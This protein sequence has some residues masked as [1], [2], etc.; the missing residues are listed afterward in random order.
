MSMSKS[1]VLDRAVL[2]RV[3]AEPGPADAGRVANA[4]LAQAPA[5]RRRPG[6]VEANPGCLMQAVGLAATVG[7]AVALAVGWRRRRP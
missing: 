3:E 2:D 5:Y 4:E 7:A 1:A 6:N